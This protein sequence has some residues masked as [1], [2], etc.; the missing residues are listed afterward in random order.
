VRHADTHADTEVIAAS[1]LPQGADESGRA[2]LALEAT[3]QQLAREVAGARTLQGISTRLISEVTPES[4]FAQILDA[5]M[6]LMSA[7]AAGIQMLSADGQSLM[8]LGSKNFHP[9][10]AAYWR[11]V[12]T[13]AACACATAFRGRQR[14]VVDN[15][16]TS[17]LL[18]DTQDLA[19]YRR[20][21]VR[22]AQ[23]T[24]LNSRTGDPLGMISTH[25]RHPHAPTDDDFRLFDVLA[26]QAADLIERA[27]AEEAIRLSEEKYRSLFES[28]GEAFYLI[29]IVR[30]KD[31]RPADLLYLDENAAGIRLIGVSVIGK[32]LSKLN[33]RALPDWLPILDR[34]AQTCKSERFEKIAVSTGKWQYFHVFPAGKDRVGV[35]SKDISSRKLAEEALRESEE[36]F[37]AIAN[38]S[39]VIIW[40]SD[41]N[42]RCVFVNQPWLDFT[43]QSFEEATADGGWAQ[44]IH[45]EDVPIIS[46][47]YLPALERREVFQ[48]DFRL[49][50]ADGEYRSIVST[51]APRFHGDGSFA[52][53]VGSSLDVTERRQAEEALATINQQLADA[54]EDERARIAREL[55][56]DVVQRLV[57]LGWRL[58][59]ARDISSAPASGSVAGK[60]E[61]IRAEIMNLAREVQTLSHRLHPAWMEYLGI[62]D[63]VA[64]L[65]REMSRGSGV[66]IVCQVENVREVLS[67]ESA[68]CLH[69]VLQE[70]LQNAIKHSRA[71]K[72]EVSLRAVPGEIEMTV[73]DFGVGFDP[74][75]RAYRG[76]GLTSMR[77]RLKAVGGRL[78]IWSQADGATIQAYVPVAQAEPDNPA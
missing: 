27:R 23:I 34:V 10:S 73:Q 30:D 48:V 11:H 72:V 35:L 55:H 74:V 59:A 77:E 47:I 42:G 44:P 1:K 54:K 13:D 53:H 15:V 62:A 68:V 36:R 9:A 78:S 51:G 43:G 22:A 76:L 39:P 71:A 57:G 33:P 49:R 46:S 40:M 18:R 17:E 70:A 37:R 65:C 60:I 52:G 31:G 3:Q 12:R 25:W 16:E 26:R 75:A 38:T 63:T 61:S 45:P 4:L 19:E 24:P 7:D 64:L 28:M 66:E 67:R 14:V 50:R 20:S 32:R 5:A 58:G 6:E 21:S 56:D 41:A 8:L 69:R 2:R 29:E